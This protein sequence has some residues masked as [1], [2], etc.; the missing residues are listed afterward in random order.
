MC[1]KIV[2]VP[3]MKKC[4]VCACNIYH[5]YISMPKGFHIRYWHGNTYNYV[6]PSNK[7][8]KLGTPGDFEFVVNYASTISLYIV[9]KISLRMVK[10]KY[11]NNPIQ[12]P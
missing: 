11:T 2:W 5:Y 3:T 7:N 4:V 12:V 6:K 1:V 9:F 8:Q 10:D